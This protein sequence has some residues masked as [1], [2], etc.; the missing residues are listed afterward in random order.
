MAQTIV[1]LDL[2]SHSVKVVRLEP[3]R[4]DEH[5]IIDFDELPLL[6][7]TPGE[8]RERQEVALRE[9]QA[10]GKLDGAMFV[11]GLPGDAA[12]TRTL[13][14]PF[15]DAR[16]IEQTLPFELEAEVPFDLDEIVV[17]WNISGETL[18]EEGNKQTE[19]LVA[20]ARREAVEE[21]LDLLSTVGIDPRH[22]LFQPFSMDALYQGV[23]RDVHGEAL[24]AP[25]GPVRTPGGTVI[26]LGDDGAEP[27]LAIVDIGRRATTVTVLSEER[28]VSGTVIL[29][30]GDDAT[31]ALARELGLPLEEA[32]RGKRK[33]AFIE[34]MGARAQFPQQ[35]Q[36]SDILKRAYAPIARRL[37]Q[38]FQADL[39]RAKARVVKVVLTGGGSRTLNLDRHLSELLNVRVARG[40]QV[41]QALGGAL[42]IG[43]SADAPQVAVA[44]SYA[45]SGFYGP[46]ARGVLDLRT[47]DFAWRGE[48]DF[49]R[50]R[51]I[52][53]GVWGAIL[54]VVLM[55]SGGAQAWV[56]GSEEGELRERQREACKTITGQEIDSPTRCLAIIQE[57]IGTQTETGVPDWSAVDTYLELSKRVPKADVL[58]R[59]ITEVDINSERL[60]AKATTSDFDAVD[61]I[62]AALQTGKCFSEVEKGK[63]RNTSGGVEFNV[64]VRLD[65]DK[66]KGEAEP[67]WVKGVKRGPVATKVR[68]RSSA[69]KQSPAAAKAKAASPYAKVRDQ[70]EDAAEDAEERAERAAEIAKQ[71]EERR[72]KWEERKREARER[73]REKA[74]ERAK[75][76][77]KM[78]PEERLQRMRNKGFEPFRGVSKKLDVAPRGRAGD[79]DETDDED[80]EEVEE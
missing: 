59:K 39:S 38:I 49:L 61:K 53:I 44:L 57:T 58:Q 14:F 64:I 7:G 80:A 72:A 34:V 46:K 76:T 65:C 25:E 73:A 32:E 10:R 17:S 47:G 6:P 33:E 68:K 22:V 66:A 4:G 31:R 41:T 74:L 18:D 70:V 12:A 35:T 67:D 51:A 52:S 45:L 30:G 77:S 55:I 75:D 71:R 23:F 54:L 5:E 16:K 2:G 27:A 79:D 15:S 60:R 1:G 56:L 37:R 50:E 21:H 19:V 48:L 40:D 26:Q 78:T 13:R 63:A 9:L 43:D 62:V 20:Y 11:T 29:H 28:V 69:P 3:R 8:L 36:I 24:V 42:P